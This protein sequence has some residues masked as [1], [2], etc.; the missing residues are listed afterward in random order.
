MYGDLA[1]LVLGNVDPGLAE[2]CR[3]HDDLSH[4]CDQQKG[5]KLDLR[6]QSFHQ[7]PQCCGH[8]CEG[9]NFPEMCTT[10][11]VNR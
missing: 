4:Y 1:V 11:P 3:R 7:P 5:W 8:S 9:T 10:I 2:H 6:W